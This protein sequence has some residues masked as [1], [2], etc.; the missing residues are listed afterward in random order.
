MSQP[1]T[2]PDRDVL[3]ATKLHVPAHRR[4]SWPGHG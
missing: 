2:V 1:S 3:L 4:I